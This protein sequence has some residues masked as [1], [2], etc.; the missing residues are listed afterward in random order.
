MRKTLFK[1]FSYLGKTAPHLRAGVKIAVLFLTFLTISIY[2]YGQQRTV[3]GTVT[4]G[5]EALVGVTIN[6]KGTSNSAFSDAEGKF[7]L[8]LQGNSPTLVFSFVGFE[9][10]E[11]VVGQRTA[12]D[13]SLV[14]STTSLDEV[15]VIGYGQAKK[16]DITGS[17]SSMSSESI[18]RTNKTN[19]FQAL[20]GQVAGVNLQMTDN[21]PGGAFNVRIR[22]S[23]TIN[24]GEAL[25]NAGFSAGQ[26]PLFIVD[27][28]FVNDI[29]FLNPADIGQMDI[30]KDAS[31]TAIYGSRGTN[32]VVIIKTK[33]GTK[34]RLSVSYDNYFGAKEAY[35]LPNMLQGADFVDYF[36]DAVVGLQ[37]AGGNTAFT[38]D[39]VNLNNF[40]RPNEIA[41]INA[42]KYTDW[43][44]LVDKRGFQTNHTI[45]L[46]GGNENTTYGLGMAYTKDEGTFEGEAFDRYTMRGNIS[47]KILPN[48]TLG[49]TNY[50]ALSTRNEGSREG[51]RSAYRLRPTG[52]PY[53][54][55]GQPV[56]FPLQGESF[57]TNPLF[58]AD[59]WVIETRALNYLGNLSLEVTPL[60]G[61]KLSSNFSPNV[62]FSR[63]GEYRARYNKATSG[64]QQ[65]T[66]AVVNN[67]NRMSYTWDNIINYDAKVGKD[68]NLNT[69]FVYSQFLDRYEN[70]N[71][72]RRNFTTDQFLFYNMGAGSVIQSV[73]SGLSKQTLESYTG[74]INYSYKSKYLLTLTGRYDGSS[75]LAKENKW[76][77]FPSAA[78][79]WRIAEEN[80]MQN[81]TTFSDLKVRLS[82]GQTGNNGAGGG[83][84]PLGSLSLIGSGFT[85]IGDQVLQTAFVSGLANQNL[86]WEKTKEWNFGLDFGLLKNRITGTLDIYNRVNTDIIFFRPVPTATGYSGV[87]DNVGEARNRG[88]EFAINSKNINKG[89]FRW[90]TSLNFAINRNKV[91]KLYGDLDEI[92]FG[93][94]GGSYIH[95][96]GYP[97]GSI[98]TWEFDGIWQLDELEEARKFG[99]QPGQ[100]KVKDIDGNGVIN[101]DDRT[102]IGNSMPKLTGGIT[103][104]LE[105]KNLDFSFF[106]YTSQ[107]VRSNSYFHISHT[108]GFDATPGRFNSLKTNYWTPDNPSNEWYQPS[109]NGPYAGALQY[110]DV[111]FVKVGYI[112][113][114]YSLNQSFLDKIKVKSARFYV[115]GQNPFTFTNYVGWDPETAVRNSYASAHMTRTWMGGVNIKF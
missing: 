11:V 103:N 21:K 102:I 49:Y 26:N 113:L 65:N 41:N 1:R 9:E 43:I 12:V 42:N 47:S 53:D 38:R 40:L 61:L 23:N 14:E 30:L 104:T 33:G 105:Y 90:N 80:F 86:T 52:T 54:D 16:S 10:Q 63:M 81:Q 91:T 22:G 73:G 35:N 70:Y 55:N 98:Y 7:T 36:K 77:F 32:G 83:L 114:G 67:R 29:S 88:I 66:R 6:E 13:V 31:A 93:V 17:V 110:P 112:T 68:H 101:A 48:V 50:I 60:K 5:N 69:T 106:V 3:T 85:N 94:Q 8:R 109:N 76:A 78:F 97:I 75:I 51:L 27:G 71:A 74:R 15:V 18:Q 37:W 59:N 115:T 96:V 44:K 99:Q 79:A 89:D 34:G 58:E 39:D 24:S 100:V 2:S 28:I 4:S 56:F 95:K 72:E 20:Q 46:S 107:G 64:N 111:S 19:A 82:Y 25:E 92:L 45:G 84:A 87:F 108:G 57:I 62:E